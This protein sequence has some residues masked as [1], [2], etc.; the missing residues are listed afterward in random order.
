M[1]TLHFLSLI[2][3]LVLWFSPVLWC[4]SGS[5]QLCLG[6]FPL[7]R[8]TALSAGCEQ[9]QGWLTTVY[10]KVRQ[11]LLPKPNL[12]IR[13]NNSRCTNHDGYYFHFRGS[14]DSFNFVDEC[15][16]L[17]LFVH[18]SNI[19]SVALQP[20]VCV[21][22]QVIL[23]S[24]FSATDKGWLSCHL[25]VHSNSYFLHHFLYSLWASFLHTMT[26]CDTV[27]VESPLL[28]LLLLLLVS[29]SWL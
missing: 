15:P 4:F 19:W 27:S 17:C 11:T 16:F 6:N 13:R 28:L 18:R 14:V 8:G 29:S 20:L 7:L 9:F 26:R 23:T 5:F 25:S 22:S 2:L 12:C 1:I 10:K 21:M 24:R 3:F